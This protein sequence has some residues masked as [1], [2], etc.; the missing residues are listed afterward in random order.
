MALGLVAVTTRVKDMECRAASASPPANDM[1][2][3][4]RTKR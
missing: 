2:E 4:S 1:Y 3:G